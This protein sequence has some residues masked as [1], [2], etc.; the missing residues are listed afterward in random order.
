MSRMYPMAT[1]DLSVAPAPLLVVNRHA[2]GGG[3]SQQTA[4]LVELLRAVGIDVDLC[5]EPE[6]AA[7]QGRVRAAV[8][9]GCPLVVAAGG[10]GTVEGLAPSL[11]NSGTALGILPLGT[12]NNLAAC[13]GIPPGLEAACAVL[14][15]GATRPVDVGE[16]RARGLAD[17]HLFL[18]Q[19]TVGLGAA[20]AP[21]G[22]SVH[23]GDWLEALR[24]LPAAARLEP[25]PVLVHLDEATAGWQAETLLVTVCNA[26]RS[27]AAFVLAPD[28][29]MDDGQLD[30][31]VYDGLHQAQL[32]A[33]L[34]EF[35]SGGVPEGPGVRRARARS[36]AISSSRS[37]LVAADSRVVGETPARFTIRPH[38][39][40]VLVPPS[41]DGG[42]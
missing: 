1:S 5:D 13:L 15:S 30:V 35:M 23:Q 32:A 31:C 25:A 28:A 37:L 17:A 26:P 34:L 16:V 29:L 4:H 33:K 22:E 42:E 27:A 3:G 8:R 12:Y 38:A 39:L 24:A 20:L 9:A 10:D 19:A 18:E 14:A 41:G 7:A 21:V 2:R 6:M 40:R 11:V 36:V